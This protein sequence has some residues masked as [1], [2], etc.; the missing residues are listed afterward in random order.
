[1]EIFNIINQHFWLQFAIVLFL[2][3]LFGS[4]LNVVIYRLPRMLMRQW[5]EE[6]TAFLAETPPLSQEKLNLWGPASHC[7]HC[8]ATIKPWQNIP[9]FSFILQKGRCHH[10][11]Q[12]IHYRYPMVEILTAIILVWVL[13]VYGFTWASFNV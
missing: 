6:C 3:L 4:F 5:Q 7:P 11:Q 2:G 12:K 1:M 8:K 13:F 9:V 10:C